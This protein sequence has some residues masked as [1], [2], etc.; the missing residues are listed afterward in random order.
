[1]TMRVRAPFR[2]GSIVVLQN[3]REVVRKPMK[4]ALPA[5][6]IWLEVPADRLDRQCDLEVCADW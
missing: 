4:R 1:M 3:G 6:M 5:E 2:D